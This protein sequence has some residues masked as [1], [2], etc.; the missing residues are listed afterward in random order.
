MRGD[1]ADARGRGRGLDAKREA[2]GGRGGMA[3]RVG[4]RGRGCG[5]ECWGVVGC[6]QAMSGWREARAAA[7]R[8]GDGERWGTEGVRDVGGNG[9]RGEARN[10]RRT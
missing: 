10:E 2:R 1:T 9:G 8:G 7:G 6:G 4:G 5:G 3:G